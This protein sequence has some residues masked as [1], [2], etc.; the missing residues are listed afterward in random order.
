VDLP[1]GARVAVLGPSGSGKS[2]LVA[3]L[4]RFLDPSRGQVTLDGDPL[5]TFSLTDVRGTVGL[6]DDDPHVFSS[7]LRE[8]LRLAHPGATDDEILTALRRAHLGD[9]VAWLPDGRDTFLGDGHAA[10]SGGER[11]RIAVA[12]ALLGDRRVL[13]LDEPTAHLDTATAQALAEGLLEDTVDQ[14]ILWVTHGRV[15]LD[16]VDAA[17]RL[18]EP[19]PRSRHGRDPSNRA[20]HST[21]PGPV[22]TDRGHGPPASPTH[23]GE[24]LEDPAWPARPS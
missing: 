3:L 24:S 4:L 1:P 14:S 9:W 16:R 23:L 8:N 12:R 19:A 10:V 22:S 7:T 6:V 13:V 21:S 11:A 18:C 20:G 5:D 2:T 15:G 17:L